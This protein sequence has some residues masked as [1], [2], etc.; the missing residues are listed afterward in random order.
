MSCPPSRP[1]TGPGGLCFRFLGRRLKRFAFTVCVFFYALLFLHPYSRRYRVL[2]PSHHPQLAAQ[3]ASGC[4]ISV[5][6]S[7]TRY[8]SRATTSTFQLCPRDFVDGSPFPPL[9]LHNF[10]AP[11]L[12]HRLGE[13]GECPVGV[14]VKNETFST[15]SLPLCVWAS[16]SKKR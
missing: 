12:R 6:H 3:L 4:H 14:N 8:R 10:L 16:S 9:P 13:R 7:A 5:N 11:S 15:K 1:I 2:F